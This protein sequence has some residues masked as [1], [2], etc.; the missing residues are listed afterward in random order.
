MATQALATMNRMRFVDGTLSHARR[1]LNGH[2][3]HIELRQPINHVA[4]GA[5]TDQVDGIVIDVPRPNDHRKKMLI[6]QTGPYFFPVE[7]LDI[8]M[9]RTARVE[10]RHPAILQQFHRDFASWRLMKFD[11]IFGMAG[12]IRGTRAAM[13]VRYQNEGHREDV[14]VGKVIGIPLYGTDSDSYIIELDSGE[15][16]V[17]GRNDLRELRLA[18]TAG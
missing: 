11:P 13:Y 6:Q 9:I 17:I 4:N 18:P 14:V 2:R 8:G 1:S 16:K 3:V 10:R 5:T 15:Q 7:V 12:E